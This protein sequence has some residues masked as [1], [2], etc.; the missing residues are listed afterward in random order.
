MW[1]LEI[2]N[3]LSGLNHKSQY[4]VLDEAIIA[5][6]GLANP[7]VQVL[8]YHPESNKLFYDSAVHSRDRLKPTRR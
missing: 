2:D 4:K 5:A 6:L 7:A 1:T 3:T 8:I